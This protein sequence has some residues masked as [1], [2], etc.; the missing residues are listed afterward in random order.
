[1]GER[2]AMRVPMKVVVAASA[3]AVVLVVGA[4]S[5]DKQSGKPG[6]A[7]GRYVDQVD[8]ICKD[9]QSK[10]G[11]L[12]DDALKQR[13]EVN[14]ALDRI[15]AIRQPSEEIDKLRVF[16]TELNNTAID[17]EDVNQSRQVNDQARVDT[18]LRRAGEA[19]RRAAKAAKAYGFSEC[20][21]ALSG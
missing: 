8:P 20:S 18:A 17:L 16:L 7:R 13:D 3:M 5:G 15:K 9:L 11:K 10:I 12:G 14:A 21:Q 6:G 2:V 19:S 4:C 1:V